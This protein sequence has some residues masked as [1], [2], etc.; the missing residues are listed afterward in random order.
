M[1]KQDKITE[2]LKEVEIEN[3]PDKEFKV[4]II[5]LPKEYG[6]RMDEYRKV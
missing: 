1:K 3:L 4:M 5:K 2:E 6:K